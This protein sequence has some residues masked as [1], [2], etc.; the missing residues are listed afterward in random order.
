MKQEIFL[1][2]YELR[3]ELPQGLEVLGQLLAL[4][5]TGRLTSPH[6][7]GEDAPRGILF[8]EG[9]FLPLTEEEERKVAEGERV[10]Q[11]IIVY[12]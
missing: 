3:E 10:A 2:L 7:D 8:Q 6:F 1:K 4:H 12:G 11:G 5:R 9:A